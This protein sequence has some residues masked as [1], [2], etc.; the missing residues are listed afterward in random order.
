MLKL[1]YGIS[2]SGKTYF[3]DT[4]ILKA[5]AEGRNVTLLVPEQ[6]AIEAERR[7]ADRADKDGILCEKLSVVS[8]RR[9]A[10]LAFRQYG[11]IEY[12]NIG[13]GGK[14]LIIWRIVEELAPQLSAYKNNRDRTLIERLFSVC[15]ELKRYCITA[16]MLSSLADKTEDD[17]LRAKL[18]DISLIYSAYTAQLK[19][20]YSD[21]TDD[22]TRLSEILKEK[23]FLRDTSLFLDSFNGFTVPEL[24]C[25]EFAMMQCD[26]TATLCLSETKGKTGYSKVEHT[27]KALVDMAKRHNIP[28]DQSVYLKPLSQYSPK[29]FRLIQ[30]KLFDF[31]YEEGTSERSDRITLAKCRDAFSQ[32]EF[33]ALNICKLV[34]NGAR[35]RD[36]AV[37]NRNTESYDGVLDVIFEKYGI[38]LFFSKRSKLTDTAIYRTVISALD[39]IQNNFRTENVMTYIKYGLC[40]V[41]TFEIDLIESYTATWGLTEARWTDEY[42][43]N[44]NPSGFT[45]IIKEADEK[46]LRIINDIRRRVC[47]PILQLKEDISKTDL[48]NG[49]KAIY[50]FMQNCGIHEYYASS[51]ELSDTTAY[52]TFISLLDNCVT[53]VGDLPINT[54]VLS[55]I[56]YL[57]AKNTDFGRIPATFDRITAGDASILRVN[58]CKHVFITDCE[59]GVFPKAATDDSFFSEREKNILSQNGIELSPDLSEQNDAEMFY[60]LSACG[61]SETLTATYCLADGKEHP[62]IGFSRLC[63]LFPKNTVIEYPSS[64]SVIDKIQTLDSSFEAALASKNSPLF[65]IMKRIYAEN[66]Q[67]FNI[68]DQRIS[69]PINVISPLS[70]DAVFGDHINITHSRIENYVKCPFSYYC[71]YVLKLGEKKYSYFRASDMG[72]Y[73]H[74]ILEIVISILYGDEYKNKDIT[75]KDIVD[76]T[77]QTINKV[78][79]D[80]IGE[81]GIQNMRLQALAE[82]LKKTAILL[83]RNIV[84]EFKN[85]DFV[86][87]YFEFRIGKGQNGID[88]LTFTL[89]DGTDINVSGIVDRVDCYEKD[90]N[91][92]VRVV[93]YKTG[94]HEHSL[95]NIA[96]GIDMQMFLYL[97]TICKS[98]KSSLFSSDGTKCG[99]ILPAGVLYQPSRLK[100]AKEAT[101]SDASD[102]V[103]HVE[104]TLLRSGVLLK[105]DLVLNAMEKGLEGKYIPVKDGSPVSKAV[106]LKTLDEF[107]EILKTIENTILE[108]GTKMKSGEASASP[109]KNKVADAC[110]YCSMYP[111]CRSK[112]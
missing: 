104:R 66:G 1:I 112:K 73:I 26:V 38:P 24:R 54:N 18:N 6:E 74:R 42:D 48:K 99:D 88:A 3:I 100:I 80:I 21:P 109:M 5:L 29:E 59:N 58:G 32:A 12:N 28:L 65:D 64:Y 57:C 94:T 44:M 37:I 91:I 40:G 15:N 108:I 10:N 103:T 61:A 53:T 7:I 68:P 98:K 25:L 34:R 33:I 76:I 107:G 30:D 102:A 50:K 101:L 16:N 85:S 87:K 79:R 20:E 60:F 43:W 13:D 81:Q 31:S 72:T 70:A 55:S 51:N 110:K 90:G 19:Y 4:Q 67:T 2:G 23:K 106:A 9:L 52:N 45:D 49:C 14:I 47:D 62:S 92:Y 78:L 71:N 36:I 95:E 8:F 46:K 75:E 86:P 41:S 82:R 39:V 27:E 11:G 93:D 22:V 96:L 35:Y 89:P 97:F 56:L 63:T 105:D 83:V 111:V 17:A 84:A 69:E 77:E